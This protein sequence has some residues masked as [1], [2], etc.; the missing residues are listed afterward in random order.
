MNAKLNR[1]NGKETPKQLV[2]FEYTDQAAR[3]VYIA[4]SFNDW[5][6]GT[7]EMINMGA[8][9]WVKDLE[10]V[11]G[12]Y[13]YRFVVDGKW[14]TDMRCAHTVPNPFGELNS[15]MIVPLPRKSGTASRRE[16][17]VAAVLA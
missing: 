17:P 1:K 3:N 4:G 12:T 9:K 13:E 10:I 5:H 6:P 14:V 16:S 11:P 8:G 2:H 7:S 15:L